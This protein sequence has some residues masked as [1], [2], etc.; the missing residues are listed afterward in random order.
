MFKEGGERM[1]EREREKGR[2]ENHVEVD[3]AFEHGQYWKKSLFHYCPIQNHALVSLG[4]RCLVFCFGLKFCGIEI[5][6]FS[7]SSAPHIS[8]ITLEE[9]DGEVL[10]HHEYEFEI[11]GLVK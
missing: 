10:A 1:R 8:W 6:G 9:R 5:P 2:E 7:L 4:R 3:W 11:P